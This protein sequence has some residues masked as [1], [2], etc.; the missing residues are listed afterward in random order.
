MIDKKKQIL[1]LKIIVCSIAMP[2]LIVV[3][4]YLATFLY[5]KVSHSDISFRNIGIGLAIQTIKGNQLALMVFIAVN[6][7][8]L[9]VLVLLLTSK[10]RDYFINELEDIT[11]NIR[12]PKPLGQF[13]HG[14]AKWLSN[15]DKTFDNFVM[16]DSKDKPT[17]GGIILNYEYQKKKSKE[18]IHYLKDNIHTLILGATRSGKS[19]HIFL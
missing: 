10:K 9:L 1:I 16:V 4:S 5:H 18:K 14:S 11:N 3:S 6:M 13:Q 8:F 19:R 12:T 7:A 15:F 2:V 17:T